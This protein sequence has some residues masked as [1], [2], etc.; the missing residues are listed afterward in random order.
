[1]T[2]QMILRQRWPQRTEWFMQRWVPADTFYQQLVIAEI[3]DVF[4]PGDLH[5]GNSP[6]GPLDDGNPFLGATTDTFIELGGLDVGEFDRIRVS[7]DLNVAGDLF[8]SLIDGH[9]LGFNQQ[10]VVADV[11]SLP[12]SEPAPRCLWPLRFFFMFHKR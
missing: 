4:A 1:M 12:P 10:Y 7:G 11:E 9:H 2:S 8:V 5:P 3:G 6:A